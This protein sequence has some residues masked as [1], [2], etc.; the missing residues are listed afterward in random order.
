MCDTFENSEIQ[1]AFYGQDLE[2]LRLLARTVGSHS[3]AIEAL[4]TIR[5]SSH[6]PRIRQEA[7]ERVQFLLNHGLL[8][9]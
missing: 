2:Q 8:G 7:G 3:Q 4:K 9:K 5:D 6:S 1:K